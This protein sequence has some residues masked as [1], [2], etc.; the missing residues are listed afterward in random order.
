MSILIDEKS[1]LEGCT[2]C[3][4]FC[5]GDIIYREEKDKVAEVRYPDECWYCGICVDRCP[6]DAVTVIF[7]ESMKNCTTSPEFYMGLSNIK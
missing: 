6:E 7:P 2:I 3:D 5:P 1:C 4:F